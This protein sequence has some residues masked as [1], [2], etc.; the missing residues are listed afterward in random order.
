MEM[1]RILDK[2]ACAYK[3]IYEILRIFPEELVKKI[4]K[5]I[6]DFFYYNMDRT[7]LLKHLMEYQC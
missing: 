2:K 4:P 7:F 6:M 1:S 3:E 5:E